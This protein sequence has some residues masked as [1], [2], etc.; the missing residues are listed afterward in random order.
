MWHIVFEGTEY[1]VE[2]GEEAEVRGEVVASFD[3]NQEAS[4]L[5]NIRDKDSTYLAP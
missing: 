5:A 4:S 3:A 1:K 2:C